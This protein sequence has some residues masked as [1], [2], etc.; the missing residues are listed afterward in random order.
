[1]DGAGIVYYPRF[2]H[3]CHAAFEDWFN[4]EGPC[5]YPDLIAKRRRGFPTVHLEADFMRPLEYGDTANVLMKVHTLRHR[6]VHF[7][8]LIHRNNDDT[9]AFKGRVVTVFTD[10]DGMKSVPLTDDI[11]DAL[12]RHVERDPGDPGAGD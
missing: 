10:L 6:S 9:P 7:G 12:A 8:Y 5:S 2:F 11:R 3:L 4:A 1:V